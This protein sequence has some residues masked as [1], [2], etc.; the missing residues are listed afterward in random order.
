V[1]ALFRAGPCL[2]PAG[3]DYSQNAP[4]ARRK[5]AGAIPCPS[6][7]LSGRGI[8][9][10]LD[11][12]DEVA[13]PCGRP[14]PTPR[15]RGVLRAV[16]A[17]ARA[18]ADVT[19]HARSFVRMGAKLAARASARSD[20]ALE[21]GLARAWIISAPAAGRGTLRRARRSINA[22]R[23]VGDDGRTVEPYG[24]HRSVQ[25]EAAATTATGRPTWCLIE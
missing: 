13:H 24:H 8:L 14:R 6:Q 18:P 5:A 23:A 21:P 1:G 19:P 25:T 9:E 11:A 17:A 7:G 22:K 2:G 10:A 16:S 3:V 4:Q 15:E 12:R 20:W